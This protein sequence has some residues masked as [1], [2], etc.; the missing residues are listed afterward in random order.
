MKTTTAIWRIVVMPFLSTVLGRKRHLP[1]LR[2]C[3][4][5]L[6]KPIETLSQEVL[7]AYLAR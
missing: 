1:S 6:V 3:V 4:S 7:E 5:F 2:K